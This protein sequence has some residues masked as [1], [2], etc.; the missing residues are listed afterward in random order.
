MTYD[1]ALRLLG[2]D[3]DATEADIKIAYKEMAQIL[4]PD[5]YA[6]NKR[7]SE[8]AN[9]QFKLVNE[10]REVLLGKRGASRRGTRQG[11]AGAS[12]AGA[13]AGASDEATILRA[14]LAGI[15][16]A[17]TQLTAQL[18]AEL[19]RRRV[20]IYLTIGGIIG[21]IL[22]EVFKMRFIEP[23][24]GTALVWGVVQLFGSQAT[25]KTIRQHLVELEKERKKCA[26]KLE[27]L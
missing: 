6:D 26:K 15:A 21:M 22:G 19:D 10:A 20:G 18:D 14:K 16:A 23:L 7:L 12:G 4:H 9:E 24:G 3:E 5:K 1:E 2:L 8:R 13:G 25:V 11:K 27:S 17:K